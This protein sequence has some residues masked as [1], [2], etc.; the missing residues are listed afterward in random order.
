MSSQ[1][2]HV[3][4]PFRK[5]IE[6]AA[7]VWTH[8]DSWIERHEIGGGPPFLGEG[9]TPDAAAAI[10]WEGEALGRSVPVNALVGAGP[11]E[12][13]VAEARRA[14]DAGFGTVKMKVGVEGSIEELRQRV[15]A[16]REA[17]SS[18]VRL[19]LDANGAWDPGDAADWIRSVW[20]YDI[21]FVEQ[22]I[23]VAAGVAALADLRT[24]C[25]VPIAVDESVTSAAAASELLAAKAADVVVVKPS[26]VGGWAVAS[27][28]TELA[29]RAGVPV[30]MSTM[31]ETGVGI[32]VALLLA[33]MEP[34]GLAHG[35][36]TADLLESDLLKRPLEIVDG[37]MIVPETVELDEEAL[38]RYAVERVG[39]WS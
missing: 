39:E 19:R 35:L 25:P 1:R 26:R 34:E 14:A 15:R 21:E 6:T 9:P 24:R 31:F 10:N 3:R 37:R 32:S 4:V 16:V 18:A 12:E 33:T 17:V 13:V 27:D 29:R 8:R 2:I 7:G 5:P 22:P 36:A 23:P 38:D 28:I 30:V 11:L 20:D